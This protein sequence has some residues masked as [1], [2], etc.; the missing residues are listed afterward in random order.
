M[1]QYP[2]LA[3]AMIA[4]ALGGLVLAPAGALAQSTTTISGIIFLSGSDTL[5]S[6]AIVTIQLTDITS[7]LS[8]APVITERVF[9]TSGAQSPFSFSLPYDATKIDA[10]HRYSIQGNINVS[11]QTLY[12]T[13][14]AYPVITF[15][16]P[17]ANLQVS[18]RKLATGGI[19]QASAGTQPLLLAGAL[20]LAGLAAAGLRRRLAA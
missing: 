4:L 13:S 1:K 12:T 17:T 5:P 14:V 6:R 19:P 20:L 3:L 15:A 18:M 16:S 8:A 11:G 7:G 2:F 9:S 10:S